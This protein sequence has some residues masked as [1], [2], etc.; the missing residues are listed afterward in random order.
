MRETNEFVIEWVAGDK[1]ATCTL[2]EGSALNNRL[3]RLAEKY[4]S[5]IQILNSELFH[6]NSSWIKI[7]PPKQ[8]S[9]EQKEALAERMRKVRKVKNG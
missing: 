2:P 7:N 3:T 1:T 6:V 5:D 8:I 4:P 9:D